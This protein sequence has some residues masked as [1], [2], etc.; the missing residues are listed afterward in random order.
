MLSQRGQICLQ[1]GDAGFDQAKASGV[2]EHALAAT[3]VNLKKQP[4]IAKRAAK[5]F[6]DR[7]RIFEI[8]ERTVAVPVPLS[9]KRKFERG[10]NQAEILASIVARELELPLLT[11]C[12]LRTG[13]T[14]LHR[15]GMDKKARAMTVDK[16][17]EI[18]SSSEIDGRNVILVD[19]VLTSGSTASACARVLKKHG[20]EGVTVVTLARAVL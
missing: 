14:Q 15:I 11:N 18:A 19:D 13:H 16:A 10:F 8:G 5:I 2:Y 1:C 17:F 7:V 20:A 4:Y 12:L 3:V 6:A 9:R